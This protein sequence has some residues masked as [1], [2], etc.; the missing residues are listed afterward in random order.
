M[1]IENAIT[2]IVEKVNQYRNQKKKKSRGTIRKINYQT[3]KEMIKTGSRVK[4]V[5]VRSPQEFL[6]GKLDYAI[7]IPLYDLNKKAELILSNKND[8]IILYCQAGVRSKKAYNILKE[9]GY[10]DLYMLD[11][12]LDNI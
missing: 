6:E 10:T 3:F 1:K 2:N 12:G 5:D 8:T 11:G 9:K 7:N 4:V